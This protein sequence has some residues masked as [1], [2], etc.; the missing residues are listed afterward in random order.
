MTFLGPTD[1]RSTESLFRG[2]DL[3][4]LP[5]RHEPF[6]IVVLEALAAGTPVIASDVGGVAEFLPE[7]PLAQLVEPDDPRSLADRIAAV[8]A[9][10]AQHP[11]SSPEATATLH[12]HSWVVLERAYAE[13]YQRAVLAT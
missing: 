9:E 7:G 2:A 13:R 10:R 6:G 4:V 8:L 12:A 5:S 1:R 3:F 11:T